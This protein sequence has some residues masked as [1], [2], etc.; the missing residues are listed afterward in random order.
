M[1][2][3]TKTK[4]KEKRSRKG[5]CQHHWIIETPSGPVSKGVCKYCGAVKEFQNYWQGTSW[6]RDTSK[7]IEL[8]M[9]PHIG[10]DQ[11]DEC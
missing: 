5:K 11:L 6:E 10:H 4:P 2:N 9:V 1:I 7:V 8:P 3:R